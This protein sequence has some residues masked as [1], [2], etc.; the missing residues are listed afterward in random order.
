MAS[1]DRARINWHGGAAPR[2]AGPS[3]VRRD[4]PAGLS[5]TSRRARRIAQAAGRPWH[6]ARPS[7]RR[8]GPRARPQP[9]FIVEG[10]KPSS[11]LALRSRAQS[12]VASRG[13]RTMRRRRPHRAGGGGGPAWSRMQR[14]PLRRGARSGARARA[15]LIAVR[16]GSG[17]KP[18]HGTRRR[19]PT[20]R[21]G[22]AGLPASTRGCACARLA[23]RATRRWH[24]P[25]GDCRPRGARG[26]GPARAQARLAAGDSAAP[27]RVRSG[28]PLARP[29]RL[30][31]RMETRAGRAN[32][33]YGLDGTAARIGCAA[34]AVGVALRLSAQN[35]AR[36]RGAGS[37]H[38]RPRGRG[39]PRSRSSARCGRVTRAA[40][41]GLAGELFAPP[42]DS[43]MPSARLPIRDRRSHVGALA[44]YRRA[45][46][47]VRLEMGAHG[48]HCRVRAVVPFRY[49]APT[50]L[51]MLGDM[52]R[53]G[54]TGLGG[55]LVRRLIARYPADLR[56]S[57]ARF[58]PPR[59]PC[60][61]ACATIAA[62]CF[63]RGGGAGRS[64]PPRASGSASSRL[65]ARDTRS[66]ATWLRWCARLDRLYGLRAR[67]RWT[68][69]APHR[70]PLRCGPLPVV[71][72][73][74]GR[75]DTLLLA[76]LDTAAQAECAPCSDAPRSRRRRPARLERRTRSPRLR[77]RGRR[78]AGKRRSSHRNDRACCA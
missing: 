39:G 43:A 66:T 59:K 20:A 64:A 15:A 53:I 9:T 18:R 62:A 23:S 14:R 19:P 42:A 52:R 2:R 21:R 1:S 31:L 47:L 37:R 11:T 55:A 78:L 65:L 51:Y 35:P 38:E 72:T 76:G 3:S 69:R 74:L 29:G 45:R 54:G 28:W 12:V 77:P 49:A 34:A 46:V 33:L 26:R 75:I 73:S 50:A 4:G 44:I 30:A 22:P 67:R 40:T 41:P 5:L 13:S 48:R 68:C 32:A 63:S 61:T 36:A 70:R 24:S 8:C 16:E 17:G 58:R 71:A 27:R 10:A 7:A 25:A 60:A 6:A 56:A 57:L